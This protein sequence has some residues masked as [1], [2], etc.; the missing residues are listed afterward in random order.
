MYRPHHHAS[1]LEIKLLSIDKK[2]NGYT[3]NIKFIDNKKTIIIGSCTT[4]LLD[5]FMQGIQSYEISDFAG[6]ASAVV[7]SLPCYSLDEFL[8][9]ANK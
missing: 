7:K 5:S 8:S 3:K 4:F 2:I 6:H 1:I 9:I